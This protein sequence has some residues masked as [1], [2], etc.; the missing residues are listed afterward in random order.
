MKRSKPVQIAIALIGLLLIGLATKPSFANSRSDVRQ[1][2]PGRRISGGSRSP[3]TACLLGSQQQKD[4]QKVIAI[5]PENNLSQTSVEHPTFWFALP[6]VNPNRSIEF[7]LLDASE[8][9]IYTQ[10]VQPTGKAG[11]AAITLPNDAP[12]LSPEQT[13]KWHLSVVCDRANRATDLVVWGWIERTVSQPSQP[14]LSSEQDDF[15]SYAKLTN[16][17]DKIAALFKLYRARMQ[18]SQT[19]RDLEEEW[20]ALL[21]S[22]DLTNLLAE[23]PISSLASAS[24][25]TASDAGY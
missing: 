7:L 19:T 11:L 16:W 9:I 10:T 21:A 6:A 1:G 23:L 25:E 20:L 22:E 15:V 18:N 17:N 8:E 12:K 2:L 14:P 13:Y 24:I 5:A 3:S 4:S